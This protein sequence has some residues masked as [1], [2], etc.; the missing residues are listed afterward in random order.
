[1]SHPS[2][3]AKPSNPSNPRVF[4][5]V[6]IGGERG[7]E[8]GRPGS[9]VPEAGALLWQG[10]ALRWGPAAHTGT[11]TGPSLRA[12]LRPRPC[13]FLEI[14]VRGM[15]EAFGFIRPDLAAPARHLAP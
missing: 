4:F 8:A 7:E 10:D 9:G 15:L 13:K 14:S 11:W 12:G 3:Q 2:P 5:D 6:D 1:M